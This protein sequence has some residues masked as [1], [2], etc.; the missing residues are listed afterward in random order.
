MKLKVSWSVKTFQG[1]ILR[2]QTRW[3]ARSL[4]VA[5]RRATMRGVDA[6]PRSDHTRSDQMLS[7]LVANS[8]EGPKLNSLV[9]PA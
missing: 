3:F 7:Q 8:N 4:T 5:K 6:I 2:S 9:V 1:G